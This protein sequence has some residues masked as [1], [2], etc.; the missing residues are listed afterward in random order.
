MVFSSRSFWRYVLVLQKSWDSL[1]VSD[2]WGKFKLIIDLMF[3]KCT[4]VVLQMYARPVNSEGA[5]R[6]LFVGTDTDP[7]NYRSFPI[8][9]SWMELIMCFSMIRRAELNRGTWASEQIGPLRL[10]SSSIN[11]FTAVLTSI[12]QR[13]NAV[14]L[15]PGNAKILQ[16]EGL[17]H[18]DSYVGP[19]LVRNRKA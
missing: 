18:F 7:H 11:R 2:L 8:R 12:Q 5:R 17:A 13:T 19:F 9:W 14:F 4:R 1:S 6:N 16:S 10:A 15:R 3:S